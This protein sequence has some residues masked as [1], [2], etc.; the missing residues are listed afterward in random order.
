MSKYLRYPQIRQSWTFL[1]LNMFWYPQTG[2]LHTL[3]QVDIKKFSIDRNG[4]TDYMKIRGCF[5]D[6]ILYPMFGTFLPGRKRRIC[7]E[8]G[9]LIYPKLFWYKGIQ[10]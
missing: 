3:C 9:P 10:L 2:I 4:G 1:T 7:C 5:R 6:F 8:R